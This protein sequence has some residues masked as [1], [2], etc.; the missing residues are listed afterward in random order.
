MKLPNGEHAIVEI[1]KLL[2]YCLDKDHPRGRHKARVFASALGLSN[3]D[4]PFLREQLKGAARSGEATRTE[5]S[6]FGA[7][8]R[9]D[10]EVL[11]GGSRAVVRSC[12]I[13]RK[14]DLVPR[15]T[16]CWVL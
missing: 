11:H 9:V 2:R 4:A 3:Q 8:Y 15:L 16:S 13:I 7:H 1:D 10:F 12:W 14:D 6:E 5:D